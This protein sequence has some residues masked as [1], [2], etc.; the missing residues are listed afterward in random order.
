MSRQRTWSVLGVAVVLLSAAAVWGL[1]MLRADAKHD[2]SVGNP[3]DYGPLTD[4]QYAAAVQIAQNEIDH[5]HARI[6]S[7]TAVIRSGTVHQPNLAGRCT[8]G[9]EIRILLIGRFRHIV[10]DPPPG[11]PDGP[12]SSVGI[13]AD[14]ASGRACL[15]GV[16]NTQ[17]KPY[18]GSANL[19]PAL[20]Q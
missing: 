4:D 12:A 14:A 13:T 1:L 5:E 3:A 15:L 16:G 8:S 19:L 7:A 11:A 17:V 9:Q 18:R 6:T 2:P 20:T 10:V